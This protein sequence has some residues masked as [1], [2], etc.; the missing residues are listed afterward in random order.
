MSSVAATTAAAT[1]TVRAPPQAGITML[2]GILQF[3][4]PTP[5]SRSSAAASLRPCHCNYHCRLPHQDDRRHARSPLQRLGLARVFYHGTLMSCK[6]L[7]ELMVLNIGLQAKDSEHPNITMF[8]VMTLT[9][10]L[11]ITPLVSWLYPPCGRSA[12]SNGTRT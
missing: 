4:A 6:G 11:A 7:V 5:T 10:T 12:R 8:V 3:Q 9:T 1:S 2:S